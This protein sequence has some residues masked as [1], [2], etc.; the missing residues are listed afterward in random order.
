MGPQPNSCGNP[1]DQGQ[2]SRIPRVASMG[3]QPNSCGNVPMALD[4]LRTVVLA[5]MGPQPNS[6]GNSRLALAPF[7]GATLQWG[8]SQT[9]VETCPH[10]QGFRSGIRLQWGHS[11]TAVE[12]FFGGGLRRETI[13]ASM[14]PQPNS[15]GN[16][17]TKGKYWSAKTGFNGATAKQLWKPENGNVRRN[18]LQAASM[19]PQPNSC[20]NTAT[21]RGRLNSFALQ[22]GHSQTAV[23]TEPLPTLLH[24]ILEGFNGA[25]AKQLWKRRDP[26]RRGI[27][28]AASMG[29][30][31]NSCG[32]NRSR[33]PPTRATA[34]F[35]GATA[36]QL[37][38]PICT[39]RPAL[40]VRSFNG[41]T[42]KQLWKQPHPS[43]RNRIREQLQWGHS[44]TAVETNP[45]VWGFVLLR[46]LQWGHSQTAVETRHRRWGRPGERGAS[47]GPQPNSCGNAVRR[48]RRGRRQAASM[49][50]QPNSCGNQCIRGVP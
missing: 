49:G 1:L 45:P 13:R 14:G 7:S 10:G 18:R 26:R 48:Q 12:T 23:E 5:S 4:S 43:P 34:S 15:C 39:P 3:P 46:R 36:K 38:K 6:C 33:K 22:W 24:E 31:P 19:G 9:A 44:Q 32:N 20:G 35:N 16:G 11:Q 17:R 42:A 27:Q 30:Q 47:M 41:A 29:P 25:T 37:W 50:P 21:A 2:T 40:R 8:H 28:T